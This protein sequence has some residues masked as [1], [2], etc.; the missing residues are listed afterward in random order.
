[1]KCS[2]FLIESGMGSRP[3]N[4]SMVYCYIELVKTRGN[5]E[6]NFLIKKQPGLSFI[7]T[8]HIISLT[9]YPVQ[10]GS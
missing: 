5:I 2:I 3:L 7:H 6:L 4:L 1:M 9:K 8:E 10:S